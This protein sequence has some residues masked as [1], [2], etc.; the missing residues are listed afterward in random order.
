MIKDKQILFYENKQKINQA[1]KLIELSM[2]LIND[3]TDENDSTLENACNVNELLS[4][5]NDE[6]DNVNDRNKEFHLE[7]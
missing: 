2:E 3:I 6:L 1:L 5:A 4:K 7:L